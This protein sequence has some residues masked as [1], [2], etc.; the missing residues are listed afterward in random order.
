M[1]SSRIGRPRRAPPAAPRARPRSPC[2]HRV[3]ARRRRT[4]PAG[5][6]EPGAHR[7]G[8]RLVGA[9]ARRSSP[10][11]AGSAGDRRCA[12]GRSPPDRGRR[13]ARAGPRRRDRR[14]RARAGR[15]PPTAARARRPRDRRAAARATGCRPERRARP[16]RTATSAAPR[17]ARPGA[18]PPH[19]RRSRGCAA[20]PRPGRAAGSAPCAGGCRPPAAPRWGC[21]S[22]SPP[23]S[24]RRARGPPPSRHGSVESTMRAAARA[25][26]GVQ[27]ALLEEPGLD[28]HLPRPARLLGGEPARAPRTAA[29][30]HASAQQTIDQPVVAGLLRANVTA[31]PTARFACRP[32]APRAAG[33]REVGA[34]QLPQQPGYLESPTDPLALERQRRGS[35]RA[36]VGIR[37]SVI[38]VERRRGPVRSRPAPRSGG[39]G[40][41][42][43]VPPRRQRASPRA[44]RWSRGDRSAAA[45]RPSSMI[46]TART[47]ASSHPIL[48]LPG[49]A[50]ASS[51]STSGIGVE[52]QRREVEIVGLAR[53]PSSRA[54]PLSSRSSVRCS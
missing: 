9:R 24:A 51:T 5:R 39:T 25:A 14:G 38:T 10:T 15:R 20:D 35:A 37:A 7:S 49:S 50:R 45:D 18:P 27:L 52:P 17:R 53:T 3:R 13:A 29:R 54:A 11:P 30:Q 26:P 12:P 34:V 21:R 46:G 4:W 36:I 2:A 1:S 8:S 16:P 6:R 28:Q 22:G 48:G 41:P 31:P 23:R 47:A 40:T 32:A 19:R 44:T 42:I 43:A 33:A